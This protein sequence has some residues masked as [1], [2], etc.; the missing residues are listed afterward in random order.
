MKRK[1]FL[2]LFADTTTTTDSSS[3]A[4]AGK[5]IIYLFRLLENAA[6]ES[7]AV[8]AFQTEGSDSISNDAENTQTKSGSINTPGGVEREIEVT[9]IAS[10]TSADMLDA[11][12]DAC[13]NGDVVECWQINKAIAG[14][15]AGTYKGWYFQGLIT[16]FESEHNAE[17]H[18]E[19]SITFAVNGTG[20]R[21]D[22]T[23]TDEQ[24]DI[25][26]YVFRDTTP[27]TGDTSSDSTTTDT[28]TDTSSDS[29]GTDTTGTDT[30]GDSTETDS[31]SDDSVG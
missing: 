7:G 16:E 29:T 28:T 19:A 25:A 24:E 3:D 26:N 21:G 8:I 2:Q 11:L 14:D 20:K 5:Q 27:Y 10:K 9:A 17:D 18:A 15:T 13:M 4:I 31:D 22:C 6:T 12:Q 23:L 30:S 1:D